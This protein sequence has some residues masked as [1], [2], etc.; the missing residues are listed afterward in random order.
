[1]SDI[2]EGSGKQFGED[3]AD[4]DEHRGPVADRPGSGQQFARDVSD[5][6]DDPGGEVPAGSG[7]QFAPGHEGDPDLEP[8]ESGKGFAIGTPGEGTATAGAH[9]HTHGHDDGERHSHEHEHAAEHAHG[10]DGPHQR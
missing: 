10:H 5:P 2:P 3:V 7:K 1:M 6:V 4:L 9:E 8:P